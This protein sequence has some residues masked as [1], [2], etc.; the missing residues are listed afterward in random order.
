MFNILPGRTREK[1]ATG[2][3]ALWSVGVPVHFDTHEALATVL[4]GA[5]L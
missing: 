2:A 1:E 4:S 3:R 5:L